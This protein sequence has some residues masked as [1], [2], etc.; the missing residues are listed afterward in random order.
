MDVYAYIKKNKGAI[1]IDLLTCDTYCE[2]PTDA[3][4]KDLRKALKQSIRHCISTAVVDV[5]LKSD[6]EV[7][8]KFI[9]ILKQTD[10]E[11]VAKHFST[12]DETS[13]QRLYDYISVIECDEPIPNADK[14]KSNY[15]KI[16]KFDLRGTLSK[17]LYKRKLISEHMW[18]LA[19]SLYENHER[20]QAN[21][22][23]LDCIIN[24]NKKQYE[25]FVELVTTMFPNKLL[26][27]VA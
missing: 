21:K 15:D 27:L 26:S 24:G 25:G 16:I 19:E 9:E 17:T 12:I 8:N 23:V 10:Q 1:S 14:L 18:N 6:F 4:Y 3:K 7:I 13:E 22:C 11:H 20:T 2:M 5:L